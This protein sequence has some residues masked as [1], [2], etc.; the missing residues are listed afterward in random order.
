MAIELY[1]SV[2]ADESVQRLPEPFDGQFETIQANLNKLSEQFNLPPLASLEEQLEIVLDQNT[3]VVSFAMGNPSRFVDR[4]HACGAL[5][6]GTATTVEEA[7][8]LEA[9]GVDVIVAQG[10][11]AGC[12][13]VPSGLAGKR[14]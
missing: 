9:G 6:F 8:E 1:L 11:E 4:I 14:D 12:S 5:V 10:A 3:P 7:I 2:H 13:G